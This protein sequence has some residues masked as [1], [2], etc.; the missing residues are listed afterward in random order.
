[1]TCMSLIG[2]VSGLVGYALA[3][4]KSLATLPHALQFVGMMSITYPAS[5]LMGRIGRK[6]GFMVGVAFALV[7]A[8]IA[9][10]AISAGDFMI[11]CVGSALIGASTAFGQYYRFAAAD[12]S[13][14]E[15]RSRAISWVLSG[16]VVAAF[17]GPNLAGFTHSLIEGT[18]FVGGY[19]AVVLLGCLSFL[20]LLFID[21]PQ[22]KESE[23][24]GEA[25]PL[26][27]IIRNPT[28]ITAILCGALAYGTMALVMTATPLAMAAKNMAFSD[29]VWV[30]QWHILGMYGPA[31]FTGNLIRRFGTLPIMLI[32]AALSAACAV[33]NLM[34]ESVTY[35]WLALLS[36]GIG[37]NFLFT[38]A[39][40]LLTDTYNEAEKARAQGF[41]DL[42]VFGGL[43]VAALLSGSMHFYL[44]WETLNATMIV[45]P[46]VAGAAVLWLKMTQRGPDVTPA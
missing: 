20:V 35:I 6:L 45:P 29:T 43:A 25:R 9:A 2:T 16:G 8:S 31:F 13:T 17:A 46:I 36:I 19:I 18:Q 44:G 40:T 26:G 37:W 21:V 4:D 38:G 15:Y 30:I 11:F 33:V 42:V 41:N 34:G 3:D 27:Q 39:T 12:V 1:M 28:Y 22:P 24:V 5:I 14:P 10:W 23:A 7:G 32:G